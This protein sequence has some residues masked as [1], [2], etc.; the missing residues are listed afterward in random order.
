MK[1]HLIIF[2]ICFMCFGCTHHNEAENICT[3]INITINEHNLEMGVRYLDK[4]YWMQASVE[5]LNNSDNKIDVIEAVM[6]CNLTPV[7]NMM[8]TNNADKFKN[9]ILYY[10]EKEDYV[11]LEK[12]NTYTKFIYTKQ[13]SNL[14]SESNEQLQC[15][16]SAIDCFNVLPT[17]FVYDGIRY[18]AVGHQSLKALPYGYEEAFTINNNIEDKSTI[19]TWINTDKQANWLIKGKAIIY[20]EAIQNRYLYVIHDTQSDDKSY[21]MYTIFENDNYAKE[22]S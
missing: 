5:H 13:A 7:Q 8:L 20:T 21:K 2:L 10:N 4:I 3:D 15:D 19:G 16:E 14:Y 1:K 6:P 11:I 9:A 12:E 17:N 22:Q 18:I